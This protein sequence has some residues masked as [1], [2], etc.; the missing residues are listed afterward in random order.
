M[1]KIYHDHVARVMQC[2]LTL[3]RQYNAGETVSSICD[4]GIK[5]SRAEFYLV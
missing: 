2:A 3:F 1:A 4:N 5:Y